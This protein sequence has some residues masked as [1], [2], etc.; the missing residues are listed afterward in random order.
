MNP[1]LV[2]KGMIFLE[3]FKSIS[4]YDC[5]LQLSRIWNELYLSV[6]AARSDGKFYTILVIS[7]VSGQFQLHA[8]FLFF[9]FDPTVQTGMIFII[10]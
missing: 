6:S 4:A 9:Y 8:I 7:A 10:H 3:S 1:A 2:Y 5:T